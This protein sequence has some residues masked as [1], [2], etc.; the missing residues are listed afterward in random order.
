MQRWWWTLVVLGC[1][2]VDDSEF[3]GW[4]MIDRFA[5]FRYEVHGKL[6]AVEFASA[7]QRK[8]DDLNCFGWIQDTI[9]GTLVGEA[10]CAKSMGPIFKAWLRSASDDLDVYDYPDTK[11]KL[12]F[13]HF[14]ILTPD[15]RTCF[16]NPPHMCPDADAALLHSEL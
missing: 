3:I 15:R 7:A 1:A 14:K 5:G 6:D 9:R 10:R 12:H 11:I 13:S 8:A 2:R 16:P 4:R